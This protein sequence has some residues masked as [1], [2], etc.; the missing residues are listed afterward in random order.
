MSISVKKIR[1]DFPYLST[2]EPY[3][4]LD[5]ASTTQKPQAVIDALTS[6]YSGTTAN[7]GRAVYKAAERVTQEYDAARATIASFIGADPEEVI[8]TSS[9]THGINMIAAG[10][11]EAHCGPGDEIVV[12]K[13]E[14]H[15]NLIPW[16]VVTQKTGATVQFIPVNKKDGTLDLSSLDQVITPK[17]KLVAVS[18][19]SNVTGAYTDLSTITK[20]AHT[21]GAK[22]LV[23]AAQSAPHI[24]LNVHEMGCDFLVFSGHK[25][26]GPTGVGVLYIRKSLHDQ[27]Q[28]TQFGGGMLES[29]DMKSAHWRQTPH[30]FEGGTPPIAQAIGLAAAI[31]YLQ[32]TI[33]FADL[34]QHEAALC[35]QFIQ[36]LQTIDGVRILGPVH[37]LA[38]QGHLVSFTLEGLHAHDSAAYLDQQNIAVR[39]GYHCAYPLS[40]IL[41]WPPSVRVSFYLYNTSEEVAKCV[42]VLQSLTR[43]L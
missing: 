42:Q 15:S 24:P 16:Q 19:I 18:H 20:R 4:Y 26:L 8:F 30:K 41:N 7:V 14:H 9:A 40:Q 6:F 21:V 27:V 11:A 1:T 28:P 32:N 3:I 13:M 23:D 17:T 2:S 22:V 10:W 12:T 33:A 43:S 39:A 29:A 37:E 25:L 38:K 36:G 35:A 31:E 5:S 34:A